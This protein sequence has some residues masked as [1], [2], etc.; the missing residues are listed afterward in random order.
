MCEL[1][2]YKWLWGRRWDNNGA[3][4]GPIGG[5]QLC[6]IVAGGSEVD[7]VLTCFDIA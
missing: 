1:T 4:A 5:A 3:E 7:L 6:S 2:Q